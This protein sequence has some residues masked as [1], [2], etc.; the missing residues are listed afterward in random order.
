MNKAR[1]LFENWHGKVEKNLSCSA[2]LAF[3][4]SIASETSSTGITG[5]MGPKISLVKNASIECGLYQVSELTLLTRNL[6][7]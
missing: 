1:G 6:R 2:R 3:T 7:P 4:N 5:R